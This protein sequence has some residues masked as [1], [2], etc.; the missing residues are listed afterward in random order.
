LSC[1]TETP[2]QRRLVGEKL[3]VYLFGKVRVRPGRMTLCLS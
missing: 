1:H 3:D 2:D